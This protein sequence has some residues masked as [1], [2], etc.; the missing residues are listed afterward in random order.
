MT[1]R[2]HAEVNR[3]AVGRFDHSTVI[4]GD[5]NKITINAEGI[6]GMKNGA[7]TLPYS[8][9]DSGTPFKVG[10]HVTGEMV[11]KENRTYVENVRP[12]TATPG[13]DKDSLK[14][15]PSR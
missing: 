2:Y 5:R 11:V 8:I 13:S 12:A 7:T 10:D 9:K 4:T 3:S 1:E 6:P 15:S 14:K